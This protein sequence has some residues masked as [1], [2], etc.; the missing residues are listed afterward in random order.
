MGGG[1]PAPVET[2]N[3]NDTMEDALEAQ[4]RL[5]PDLFKAESNQEF[6]RP[7]YARLMN[8][9]SREGLLGKQVTYDNEGRLV[10]GFSGGEGGRYQVVS[11]AIPAQH[12][13]D[14]RGRFLYHAKGG[15]KTTS[16]YRGTGP[17]MSKVSNQY[18]LIDSSTGEEKGT[19]KNYNDA[20]SKGK[21]LGA[22]EF[23]PIYKKDADGNVITN[24]ELAGRTVREGDGIVSLLAGDGTSTF[25][26]GTTRKA[27]FDESGSFMGTMA[28]EQDMLERVKDRNARTEIG[29]VEQYGGQ[30]TDAYRAQGGIQESLDS[31]NKLAEQGTDHGG[32]RTQMIGMA[33]EELALGG[34]LSDREKRNIEQASRSAM[35]ARGRGRDFSA[36]VD[37]VANNDMFS[38]QRLNERRQFAGQVIGMAD[39]GRQMDQAFK[40]QRIGLEQATSADPF[41]ALTGRASGASVGA[42]QNLYGNAAAGINA[43]PQ[44][45]NPA[46]GAEF[47][48]NQSAMVNSYNSAIYGADQARSGAIIGGALSAVGSLGGGIAQGMGTASACWVA[49]EVYGEHNPT[50][51]LFRH[52]MLFLSPFWFR[53]IYLT[54]G[55]R[56]ARFIK[57]KP[58]LKSRI[59]VWMDT[60]I[61]EVV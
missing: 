1:D 59:R 8:E 54:F 21:E 9:I 56:F 37:E 53:S 32:L 23:E 43:G 10:S 3:Y 52:W 46:Q 27:G 29:L 51:K 11:Q 38:R 25:S 13:K 61:K 39:Q 44:L 24:K 35:G 57:N 49:R 16:S 30:L 15:G 31:Y 26:D 18:K 50:W 60:K 58:R 41:L 28:L 47:M 4:I 17:V 12:E 36:V 19:Y 20:F 48:A 2:N 6:G 55:E 33:Q 34:S 42:G 14:S 5:A 40:A 22:G 7:A 45:F